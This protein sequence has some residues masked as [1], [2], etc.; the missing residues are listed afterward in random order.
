MP[1]DDWWN[2]LF[3]TIDARNTAGFLGF[4]TADAEFRFGNSPSVFGHEAIRAGVDGFFGSIAGCRHRA[5]RTW[6]DETS[7]V[8]QGEV[9]YTRLDGRTVTLP[10][11]NVFEM[12]GDRVSRYLIYN[13]L[14][15]L[16][17]PA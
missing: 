15:P 17:A 6:G 2:G 8:C 12:R 10:F 5:L 14:A 16:F 13:D 11:V 9:T 3:A 7:A 4:L 1:T